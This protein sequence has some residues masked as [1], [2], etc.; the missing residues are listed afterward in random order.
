VVA[1]QYIL[2][3]AEPSIISIFHP[4]LLYK[5]KLPEQAGVKGHKNDSVLAIVLNG[6]ALWY[7]RAV[8]QSAPRDPATVDQTAVEAERVSRICP[9]YMRPYGATA[10][11]GS[12]L[13]VTF[14]FLCLS[15]TI[16]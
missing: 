13:K 15:F 16:S 14:T 11:S 7:A 4:L 6:L 8:R 2:I 9:S 3:I 12:L 1:Q 10:P 5:L